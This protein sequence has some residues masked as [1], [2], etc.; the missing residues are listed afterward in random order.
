MRCC[1]AANI[2]F[3]PLP[4]KAQLFSARGQAGAGHPF[5]QA[6]FGDKGGLQLSE[7]RVEVLQLAIKFGTGFQNLL[8]RRSED[9]VNVLQDAERK[10]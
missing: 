5:T 7:L 6:A 9:A 1:H 3:T 4:H 10:N 8:L 2:P